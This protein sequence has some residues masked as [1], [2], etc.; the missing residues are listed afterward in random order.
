MRRAWPCGGGYGELYMFC[1][2]EAI[3]LMES[4]L[5][6]DDEGDAMARDGG[7]VRLC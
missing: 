3:L 1:G 4:E 6:S 5:Y 7:E 2:G